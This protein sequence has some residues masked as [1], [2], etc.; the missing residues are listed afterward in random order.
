MRWVMAATS[1][2]GRVGSSTRPAAK[3]T[4]AGLASLAAIRLLMGESC[5]R[6]ALAERFKCAV[7]MMDF[8][9]T[10]EGNG[11]QWGGARA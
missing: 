5:V 3:L 2:A 7:G 4:R 11:V 8:I 1:A 6:L 10:G 9:M